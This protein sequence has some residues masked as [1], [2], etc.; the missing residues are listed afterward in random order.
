MLRRAPL[1]ALLFCAACA[2]SGRE[3]KA[4]EEIDEMITRQRYEE[5]VRAAGELAEERPDDTEVADA[6][7]RASVA[8]LL[9]RARRAT[10]AGDPEKAL[11]FVQQAQAIGPESKSVEMWLTKTRSTL[12]RRW[13]ERGLDLHAR[14]N[15]DGAAIAYQHALFYD[16]NSEPA[17]RSIA[18]VGLQLEYRAGLGQDYYHEGVRSLS[19]YWLER[20]RSRFS[21]ADKY[22][23]DERPAKRAEDV[24]KLLAQQRL[25]VARELENR[26]LFAAAANEYRLALILDP[27]LEEAEEH[28]ERNLRE[29]VAKRRLLASEMD[30][31]RG[32]LDRA[33]ERLRTGDVTDLQ[34]ERF[35]GLRT[36]VEEARLEGMYEAARDRERD[37]RYEEAIEGYGLLLAET[38]FFKDARTRRDTLIGYVQQADALWERAM[39]TEDAQER[40]A[41]LLQIDVFWP[42][43]RD[44]P[45]RLTKL[46]AGTDG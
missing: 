27:D 32:E 15:L 33:L 36:R 1:L 18:Q 39:A 30:L 20:A 44:L 35:A 25:E 8:Y 34:A 31:L 43:Y 29:A 3:S 7:R 2:T 4:I 16:P 21:Y 23:D 22:L 38:D 6:H 10:F 45:E 41:L 40:L 14:D 46:R 9:E 28:R 5:A 12:A 17:A 24:D 19:A 11:E 37:F 26:E 13:Y 42:E